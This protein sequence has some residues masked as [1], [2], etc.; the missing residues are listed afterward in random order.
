MFNRYPMHDPRT[1][2]RDIPGV[3]DNLFPQLLTGI[4]AHFN[5]RSASQGDIKALPEY[6][7]K[8]SMLAPSMLFEIAY[9]RAEQQLDDAGTDWNVCLE[10]AF[11]R[12]RRHFNARLPLTLCDDDMKVA[13]FVANN[14]LKML[15]RIEKEDSVQKLKCRPFIPGY[16]WIAS[17]QGDFSIGTKLIEVKCTGR[18]FSSSDYRQV[19]MYWLLSYAYAIEN[20]GVEWSHIIFINPR[21]NYVLELDFD[22]IISV[23]AS[24]RSKIDV[25][26]LFSSMVG[27]HAPRASDDRLLF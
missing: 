2:A 16:Q 19:L 18:H 26:E 25:L 23:I 17:G 20:D 13:N 8:Q 10:K 3:F 22:D 9:A 5:R 14:L 15:R 6:C 1:V 7:V 11:E 24:G 12:Q 4:V 21:L 27:D